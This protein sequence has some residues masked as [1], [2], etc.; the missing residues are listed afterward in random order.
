MSKVDG[1]VRT[2]FCATDFSDASEAA[3]DWAAELALAHDATLLL[4]HAVALIVPPVDFVAAPPAD[5]SLELQEAGRKR[6][7]TTRQR[8]LEREVKAE[9]RLLVGTAGL[10]LVDSLREE[11]PDLVVVGTRGLTGFRHLF[12]GSTAERIVQHSE[13]PVLSVHP[14]DRGKHRAIRSILVPTDFSEDAERALHEAQ[15]FGATQG[16]TSIVLLNVYYTPIE[17]TAYGSIPTSFDY[18]KDVMGESEER[19]GEIAKR[20]RGEGLDV[21]T[22]SKEGYPPEVIVQEAAA[23]QV[24]LI[25][26]GTQG[27]SGF[28][29][30]LLGSTA[31]R[32][33][34]HA[35]CP[36]LT[37]RHRKQA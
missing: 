37:V 29:H 19:L 26:M 33:V 11:K 24:D 18:M 14:G 16:K 7:E 3:V 6:L 34:Q 22:V 23:R 8:L 31:E 32:V 35:G 4:V 1:P 5:M 10:A 9:A 25:A 12:L 21:D 15:R 17:Y 36:V 13:F 30:L 28:A 27:R 2:I 20:L